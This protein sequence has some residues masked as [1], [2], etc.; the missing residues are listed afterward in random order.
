[1]RIIIYSSSSFGGCYDYGR[2]IFRAYQVNA[3]VES[4]EWWVP[5]NAAGDFL[6]GIR[7]IMLSD[8]PGISN[9]I[10]RQLHFLWRSLMNPFRLY[11]HLAAAPDSC[12]ILN[13]FEQLTAPLWVPFF[14]W[15]FS[16]RHLFAVI[17][18]DPD[19]DAYPP[20]LGWTKYCMKKLIS[21][22]DV[23]F[24]HAYLP[25]KI[26]YRENP[27]C[28]FVDLPHGVFHLPEPDHNF[29]H[30]VRDL[31][32]ENLKILSIPGNIRHEKN[33]HL[34]IEALQQL[35]ECCLLI[36]GAASNARVE[37][38]SYRELAERLGVSTRVFWMEAYLSPAELAAVITCSD[39]ILL[40]YAGSFTSQSGIFN[41]CIPF[42]KPMVVSSGKSGMAG[43]M[44]QYKLGTMVDGIEVSH[45][46]DAIRAALAGGS[47]E[48]NWK[49][50]QQYASWDN[51]ARIGITNF[52]LA[53]SSGK[54]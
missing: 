50:Y 38:S 30:Q 44:E 16:G 31:N 14:K 53:I 27:A 5:E 41:V 33:Y 24:F 8:K 1:M 2:E 36:A 25:D 26:Y 45:L 13:D 21:L 10:L 28:Q 12:V 51:N 34:A 39:L 43:I 17:L 35:P 52:Q 23:A 42:Q 40:N 22:C 20:S 6:P 4:A 15:A 54:A 32:R 29:L 47:R 46:V 9:R 19:R 11:F 37:I 49:S 3:Q 48:E 18:H 7:K